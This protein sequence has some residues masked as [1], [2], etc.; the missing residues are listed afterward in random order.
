MNRSALPKWTC[1]QA[2]QKNAWNADEDEGAL[3]SERGGSWVGPASRLS[4]ILHGMD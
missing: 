2:S 1:V 4:R 3:K